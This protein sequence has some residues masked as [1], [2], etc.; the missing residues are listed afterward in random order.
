LVD[1]FDFRVQA[2]EDTHIKLRLRLRE[3]KR[4]G[5]ALLA[6]DLHFVLLSKVIFHDPTR[7]DLEVQSVETHISLCPASF[8]KRREQENSM[9]ATN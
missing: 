1:V 8:R 7:R 5:K 9:T 6:T 3:E 2:A 4:R